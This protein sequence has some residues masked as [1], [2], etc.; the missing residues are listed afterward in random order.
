MTLFIRTGAA[1]RIGQF[2]TVEKAVVHLKT[3]G[4]RGSYLLYQ[5]KKDCPKPK[6]LFETGALR[7]I[8]KVDLLRNVKYIE[9]ING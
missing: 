4:L 3:N 1:R 7:A 8:M 5:E 9:V 2:P 6:Y